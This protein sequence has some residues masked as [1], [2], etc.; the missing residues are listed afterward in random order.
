MNDFA[1]FDAVACELDQ[2]IVQCLIETMVLLDSLVEAGILKHYFGWRENRCE[3]D[4]ARFPMIDGMIHIKQ[5]DAAN[6][7]V[8]VANAEACHDFAHLLGN[9]K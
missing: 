9:H 8:D 3:V 1:V 6:H 5:V 4:A 2:L 7:L